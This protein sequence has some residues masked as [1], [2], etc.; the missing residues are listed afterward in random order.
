MRTLVDFNENQ[1]QALD[2]LSKRNKQS[3]AALIRSAVDDFLRRNNSAQAKDAFGAWGDHT[4]DGLEYQ[5]R[6]RSEW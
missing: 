5:E 3:R 1:I 6:V 4:V 2:E